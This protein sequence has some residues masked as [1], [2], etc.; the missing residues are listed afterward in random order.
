MRR[1]SHAMRQ[2][3]ENAIQAMID[4]LDA[5]GPDPEM[6]PSLGSLSDDDNQGFW[7]WSDHTDREGEHDG[8]EPQG[9]E[10]PSLGS[11]NRMLNQEHS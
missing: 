2:R 3:I 10:E 1:P 7:G 8:C 4:A 11:F 9:D 6:E 5:L